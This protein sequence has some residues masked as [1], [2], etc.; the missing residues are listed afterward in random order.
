MKDSLGFPITQDYS[1]GDRV[2]LHPATDAGEAILTWA[3]ATGG[4]WAVEECCL[5]ALDTA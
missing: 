5:E 2:Q 4:S 3:E 1:V